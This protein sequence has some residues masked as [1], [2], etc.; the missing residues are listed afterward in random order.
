MVAAELIPAGSTVLDVGCGT[1]GEAIFLA[2][3]GFAAIGVDVS[4]K[5]LE[6][7]RA[8]AEAAGVEVSFRRADA[9]DLPLADRS[10]GFA[11]DRGCFH[12]VARDRRAAYAREMHRVLR[13]GARLLLRGARA[14]SDE[15]GV[16]AVDE[17][18]VDRWFLA[19]GFSRGPVVPITLTAES[20]A[21]E[22]NLVL[23]RRE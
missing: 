13:P 11:T 9:A 19:A 4:E 1:G 21:L 22:G 20:G 14:S 17:A 5:A 6:I 16:I 3:S 12:V 15:E 10:I 23:L 8:R 2:R 7:A 18:E